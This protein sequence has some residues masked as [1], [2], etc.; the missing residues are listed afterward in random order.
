V[1]RVVSSL[2]PLFLQAGLPLDVDP[3]DPQL[4][5]WADPDKLTQILGNLLANSLRYTPQGGEVRVAAKARE[6]LVVFRVEDNGIGIPSEDLPH[7][8]ERF[9]RVEK[10]RS[11]AGGGSGIGLAVVKA[12]VRQMG[13]SIKAE[14][15]PGSLTRFTFTLPRS[16]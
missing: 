6:S 1:E 2:R 10:S 13:G 7:V 5:V 12:L 15:T 14:S 8:F 11:Q 4:G 9:Y 3:P 16:S